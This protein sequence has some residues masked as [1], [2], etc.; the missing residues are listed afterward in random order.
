MPSIPMEA[1][2]SEVGSQR[3]DLPVGTVVSLGI[4]ENLQQ[5]A[6]LRLL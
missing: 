4:I 6:L 5:P 3:I 1:H 2:M